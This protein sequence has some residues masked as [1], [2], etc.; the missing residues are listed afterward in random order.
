MSE[1]S[2]DI[3]II[4]T[5]CCH[6]CGGRCTLKAHVKD[7][8][9]I[10]FE[11]DNG[12]DPQL[13]A[14][15][16]GRAYRQKVYHPDR[17]KF[18]MRRIGERGE[19]KFEGISWDEALD[20]VASKMMEIKEKYGNSSILFVPGAGNQGMLH[21]PTPSGLVLNQFGGYTR[22]WGAPS[23]EGAL[24][25]SIATYGTMMTGNA[26][27]DLLN[28]KLIIMWGWNPTTTIWDPGT[29]LMFAKAK[30]KG[31]KIV[32]IDP[33]FTDSAA[34]FA[35]QWIPIRPGT[36]AAMLSAMAYVII[37]ENLQDQK[38]IDK[39]TVGFDKYK[40]YIVGEEDGIP[41]TPKWAEN[42]KSICRNDY[43]FS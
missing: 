2:S 5:G 36:D 35:E 8:K 33:I 31:I 17:L 14:C 42:Y 38:F 12:D 16:R 37:T 18:P 3:K 28:S 26:R 27:E 34:I 1:N 43:N 9:I 29:P 11:T 15:L 40:A 24:F 20:E 19:G 13:R 30:E 23:Y 6:D 39:Y 25:A 22:M 21:G 32:N 4:N 41:K 10:R 7:G